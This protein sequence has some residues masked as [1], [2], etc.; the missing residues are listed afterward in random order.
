MMMA[1][2]NHRR[3]GFR[4]EKEGESGEKSKGNRGEERVVIEARS[5][6]GG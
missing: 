6:E 4:Y 3:L 2:S 5:S 1:T